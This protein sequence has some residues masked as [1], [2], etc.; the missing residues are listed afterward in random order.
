VHLDYDVPELITPKAKRPET[1]TGCLSKPVET[2]KL[3]LTDHFEAYF[4][5]L[6]VVPNRGQAFW[7]QAE[8]GAGKTHFLASSDCSWG[9]Q[10]RLSNKA[11]WDAITDVEV[12]NERFRFNPSDYSQLYFFSARRRGGKGPLERQSR[13]VARETSK[14]WE[15]QRQQYPDFLS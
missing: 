6:L 5:R 8:Y 1:L 3:H 14:T 10:P 13:H 7:I 11:I 9:E 15:L 4:N 12:R 2:V